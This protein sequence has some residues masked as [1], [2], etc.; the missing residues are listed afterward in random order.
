MIAAGII[1]AL[2]VNSL[3][4]PRHCRVMFL[5]N[6]SRTIGIV[7]QLYLSLS[8]CAPDDSPP[9]SNK[10][11]DVCV[12]VCSD[13]FCNALTSSVLEKQKILKLEVRIRNALH[14]KLHTH[15]SRSAFTYSAKA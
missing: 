5:N 9:P 14:R 6:I 4:F 8:R 1:A 2:F 3:F 11:T 12:L 15:L 13:L 7:S 10:R